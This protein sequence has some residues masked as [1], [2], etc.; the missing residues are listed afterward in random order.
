MTKNLLLDNKKPYNFS[1]RRNKT[2]IILKVSENTTPVERNFVI[3][4]EAVNYFDYIYFKQ[5]VN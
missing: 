5:S 2:N 3:I 4:S 1:E